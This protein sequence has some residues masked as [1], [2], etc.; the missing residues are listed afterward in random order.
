[1]RD[2]LGE[3]SSC[4]AEKPLPPDV[5]IPTAGLNHSP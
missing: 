4:Q 1:M 2:M 5:D 3:T